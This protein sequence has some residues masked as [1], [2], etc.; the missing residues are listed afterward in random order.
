MVLLAREGRPHAGEVPIGDGA[1]PGALFWLKGQN[2]Q[3]QGAAEVRGGLVNQE[4]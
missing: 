2:S 1:L 4:G 3:S